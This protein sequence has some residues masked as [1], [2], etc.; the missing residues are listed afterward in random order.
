MLLLKDFII[1]RSFK[2]FS[3]YCK[4][5]S[6]DIGEDI[7]NGEYIFT[8]KLKESDTFINGSYN[9][10]TGVLELYITQGENNVI[11]SIITKNVKDEDELLSCLKGSIVAGNLFNDTKYIDSIVENEQITTSI[12]DALKEIDKDMQNV[13]NK[14]Y[15]LL[16]QVDN[17]TEEKLMI[18]TVLSA[19]YE[20]SVDIEDIRYDYHSDE[21]DDLFYDDEYDEIYAKIA[22]ARAI[23]AVRK[24]RKLDDKK[25]V[26]FEKTVREMLNI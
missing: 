24:L 3:D 2:K 16:Q 17:D 18:D 13:A 22:V 7:R 11:D 5:I 15:D 6:N 8:L 21:H 20:L 25:V 26:E 14:T 23:I 10:R 12:A 9:E 19:M 1:N 4:D